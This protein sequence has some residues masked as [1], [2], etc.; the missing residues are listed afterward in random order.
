[1]YIEYVYYAY[2]VLFILYIRLN[3]VGH[4]LLYIRKY[5]HII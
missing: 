2:K 4:Y 1:M 3:K 5:Y